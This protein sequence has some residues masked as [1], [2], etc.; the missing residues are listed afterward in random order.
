[1]G[2]FNNIFS[3]V[4][5]AA[6]SVA[7][8]VSTAV[9]PVVKATTQA[10]QGVVSTISTATN[11]IEGGIA[12]A[13][14]GVVSADSPATNAER[15]V[16]AQVTQAGAEAGSVAA[17]AVKGAI[18]QLSNSAASTGSA[19]ANAIGG[20]VAKAAQSL[21]SVMGALVGGSTSTVAT[22]LAG[23]AATTAT[24]PIQAIPVVGPTAAKGL[25]IGLE[26]AEGLPVMAGYV[27]TNTAAAVIHD[28]AT[29][30]AGTAAA[31]ALTAANTSTALVNGLLAGNVP[32]ALSNALNALSAGLAKAFPPAPLPNYQTDYAG[33]VGNF[34]SASVATPCVLDFCEAAMYADA[35]G[36]G[37]PDPTKLLTQF[38]IPNTGLTAFM[39]NGKQMSI[40]DDLIGVSGEVWE[41]QQKQLIMSFASTNP[42]ID[43]NANYAIGTVAT[44][45]ALMASQATAGEN[46]CVNFAESVLSAAAAQGISAS[47]VY[48]TGYSLGGIE[49]EYVGQQTG[50]GGVGF[51]SFGIPVSQS[52]KGN[53]DNFISIE[54]QGDPVSE[55]ASDTFGAQPAAPAYAPGTGT[56]PHYGA[57]IQVGSAADNQALMNSINEMT[58]LPTMAEG[59]PGYI[60]GWGIHGTPQIMAESLGVINNPAYLHGSVLNIAHD[61]L[62]QAVSAA[63]ANHALL[64]S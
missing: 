31:L 20:T 16:N 5:S 50:I 34:Q 2:F 18:A 27:A 23:I 57:L 8:T 44:D 15:N 7:A 41:T 3:N 54:M 53:G 55:Y 37:Y 43:Y 62:G 22:A 60:A 45:F 38:G 19:A 17:N 40:E 35:P 13:A 56:L 42:N 47:Q 25:Q 24:L 32:G 28:V 48:T 64:V 14:N 39:V 9:N 36:F 58:N 21:T 1:M 12:Q 46:E 49:S 52:A 63:L 26:V 59:L 10:A 33:S 51:A 30:P 4:S 11:A 6:S 61:N 29:N